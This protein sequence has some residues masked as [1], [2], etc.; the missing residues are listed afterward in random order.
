MCIN[1]QEIKKHEAKETEIG[2]KSE[3]QLLNEGI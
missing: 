1:D 3:Q 2:L